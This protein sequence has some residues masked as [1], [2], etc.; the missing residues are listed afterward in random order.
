M[1]HLRGRHSRRALASLALSVCLAVPGSLQGATAR[2]LVDANP[3]RPPVGTG[4]FY[5]PPSQFT[6]LGGRALFFLAGTTLSAR[7]PG[8]GVTLWITDGSEKG[9]ELVAGFCT[10]EV[11]GCQGGPRFLGRIGAVEL[12]EIPTSH[13]YDRELWRTDGTPEGTFLLQP[14]T[15][16]QLDS[17]SRT[18]IFAG[19]ALL[20]AGFDAEAGCE[21]WH[22]DGTA[23][24]TGKVSDLVPG[25]VSSSP[26]NFAALGGRVF[27]TIA[28]YLDNNGL[29]VTDGTPGGTSLVA[30]FPSI[31]LLTTVG[32]RMF[33]VAPD[34]QGFSLS[35]SDGTAG[36]TRPL[37]HF[38]VYEV[39]EFH[40]C[41]VETDF[42]QP[43]G[44]GVIFVA[45]DGDGQQFWRSDGT[46]GGTRR[47]TAITSPGLLGL[48]GGVQDQGTAAGL[49]G[50][51]L[52][53]V[54]PAGKRS[55]LWSSQ[56]GPA[57]P[58]VGCPGGCPVVKS[59]FQ[60]VPGGRRVVFAGWSRPSKGV[61]L[62]TSDGTAAGTHLV[63][64]LCPGHC[65]SSP[66]LFVALG[67]AVYFSAADEEGPALWRTDG[68]ATGTV[69]L[70]RAAFPPFLTPGGAVLGD[71]V[72]LGLATGSSVSQLW[73][74]AGSAAST[75][76]L[77]TF[78]RAASSSNPQFASLG[79]RV[80]FTGWNGRDSAL[81]SSDGIT[82]QQLTTASHV[83]A[84]GGSF[85]APIT[86]GGKVFAFAGDPAAEG[87]FRA[88]LVATDGTP[89]GTQ[90]VAELGR[91]YVQS[92]SEF[93]GRLV[94]VLESEDHQ[95]ISLW[96]NDG[97]A[98]GTK[99]LLS[100]LPSGTTK[101]ASV[102]GFLYFYSYVD[103]GYSL[104]RS[105]GTVAGTA[106]FAVS[107]N[108]G[109]D[110]EVAT[111]GGQVFFTAGGLLYRLDGTTVDGA[112]FAGFTEVMGLTEH[113]GRLLFFGIAPGDSPQGGL[114]STDGT[115][116][117]T[118]LVAEVTAQPPGLDLGTYGLPV[119]PRLGGRR[120]FRGWDAGHGFELWITD[121]TPGGTVR[122]DLVPGSSSS[123]PD[124]FTVAAG[125][126]WFTAN[127][128]VHG[129]EIWVSDG[130][131]AGTHLAV[132]LVPGMFSA[133]PSQLTPAGGNLFF[134]AYTP[135][136]GFEP[137]VLPLA[138]V[139]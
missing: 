25:E 34:D 40:D 131:A 106:S 51:L 123:F 89:A 54:T 3:A 35:T 107:W 101:P 62:W 2:L 48:D 68:T 92:F 4:S 55:Q 72:V 134:S 42:L 56:G 87:L 97:T 122:L 20:F 139:P 11:A 58:L 74:T 136:N 100:L 118:T 88:S 77:A 43:D 73:V 70:G 65:S 71:Q 44:D 111:A 16:P 104:F 132:E 37:R 126:F 26:Q 15:C 108:L 96:S 129:R 69:F 117:G 17:P 86:A 102:S 31:E 130:T 109:F 59:L 22:S 120:L 99:A 95:R 127:D 47:L 12:F 133:V 94:F 64:D 46:P 105:D 9:T 121:G 23:A 137:W 36:G 119:W 7:E 38:A 66:D 50:S 135:L 114:W 57:S 98:G 39:C 53:L 91:T 78:D 63:R 27:F 32:D 33:F 83:T 30:G 138:G 116:A 60:P 110:P 28:S 125:R 52:L 21:L 41:S 8:P 10:D 24:G 112:T 67:D 45:D 1:T 85:L 76:P 93:G 29:W 124:D 90:K 80:V 61:E 103:S 49:P 128:A 14:D 5:T 18:E 113:A 19:G 82:T 81:W 75:R 6:T 79:E 13:Y 84:Q 115:T